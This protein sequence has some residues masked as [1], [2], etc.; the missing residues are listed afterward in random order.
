MNEGDSIREL[1]SRDYDR[2][3]NALMRP[4]RPAANGLRTYLG[5]VYNGGSIPTVANRVYLTRPVTVAFN[6]TE[7]ATPAFTVDT[8]VSAPVL[9]ING[10]P[11]AGTNILAENVDGIWVADLAA[12]TATCAGTLTVNVKCGGVNRSGA[13]VTITLGATTLVATTNVS[14]NATFTPGAAGV[15]GVTVALSGFATYTGTFTFACSNLAL[16]LSINGASNTMSGQARSQCG[17]A[18][19]GATVE[20]RSGGTLYA[21]TT[22]NSSG[23]WTSTFA[24]P[25]ASYDVTFIKTGFSN[26]VASTIPLS[27]NG[28]VTVGFPFVTMLIDTANYTC[29][30][31]RGWEP[32]AHTA[33]IS[34]TVSWAG[35][36]TLTYDVTYG[37]WISSPYTYSGAGKIYTAADPGGTIGTTFATGV[38]AT[39]IFEAND[40]GGTGGSG[41]YAW[42]LKA[43]VGNY[44]M[45]D[46]YVAANPAKVELRF[47]AQVAG[48]GPCATSAPP[49]LCTFSG[50]PQPDINYTLGGAPA[51]TGSFTE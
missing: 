6:A 51:G 40:G 20:I 41:Y 21:T 37:T 34:L 35:T 42:C 27:C 48:D 29:F 19:P 11:T 26:L 25:G 2:F 15:W 23:N 44:I 39:I 16:N 30:G 4:E 3:W 38:A 28:S 10:I 49:M 22:T 24:G 7:G 36:F 9:I 46:A 47:Y 43:P 8:S 13:T 5:Q 1:Y 50:Y 45:S 14:G 17:G 18:I 32:L 33:T 12:V 31:C